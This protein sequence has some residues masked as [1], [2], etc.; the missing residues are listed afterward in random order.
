MIFQSKNENKLTNLSIS[1][2]NQNRFQPRSDFNR[3]ELMKLAESIE[4]NGLIQ[5]I[6][7]RRA[8]QDSYELIV[9]ER[10]LR[11]CVMAGLTRIPAVVISCTQ[12]ESAVLSLIENLERCDLNMFEQAKAIRRLLLDCRMTQ[13]Q[14][15]R[16]LG[17]KQSTIANKLRL[18]RLEEDEQSLILSLGLT[19]RHA[20]L[21][22]KLEG[23][24][25][26]E[27]INR[28]AKYSMTVAQT[29]Q[30]IEN[31]LA[32]HD[33]PHTRPK[34]VIKDVRIF[35]NT[36][37]K[38]LQTMKQSGVNAALS[39]KENDDYIEYTVKIVKAS[40]LPLNGRVSA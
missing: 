8:T 18:L 34:I 23:K 16:H 10:R 33:E 7:V 25:R 5:P 36:I 19:E 32:S 6:V 12:R 35:M 11:A 14:V 13:E 24:Q 29:E 21:F 31:V 3:E 17:K 38:A 4:Q 27:C 39:K 28:A 1:Q 37:N 9:G 30:M 2:I 26:V 20:R 40:A 15:A 22:L